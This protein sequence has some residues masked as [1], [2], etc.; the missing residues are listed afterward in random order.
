[1]RYSDNIEEVQNLNAQVEELYDFVK[2]VAT[3]FDKVGRA[4]LKFMPL[5]E[6]P[7]IVLEAVKNKI[8]GIP[9]N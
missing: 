5:K 9:P 7:P 3:S 1:M 8:K 2:F 4:A 6:Y